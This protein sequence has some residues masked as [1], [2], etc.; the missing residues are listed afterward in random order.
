MQKVIQ[1]D[2]AM[3]TVLNGKSLN[4]TLTFANTDGELTQWITAEDTSGNP[5]G[6]LNLDRVHFS[7]P[8]GSEFPR[9]SKTELKSLG[10]QAS[11]LRKEISIRLGLKKRKH[12]SG[13]PLVLD[14]VSPE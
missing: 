4:V 10:H 11:K 2:Q 6:E 3:S 12:L 7:I 14:I 1:N 5:L 9:G 13:R 8:E